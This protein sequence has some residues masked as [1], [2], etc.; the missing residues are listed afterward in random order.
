GGDPYR[1]AGPSFF[2]GES[3]LF[4]SLNRGKESL[5]LNLKSGEGRRIFLEKLVP[6]FDA[7]IENFSPGT[8]DSL[9]LGYE[10]CKEA[11]PNI[12]YSS[13]S[14][15]GE[16]G[17]SREKKGFDLIL[18]SV[19]GIMDLTGEKD[20]GPV[21]VGI[22]ITDFAAGFV[23][24][25]GILSACYERGNSQGKA[26][27]LDT[28]LYESSISL[29]SI[30]ACDYFASGEV[31]HRMGSASPTFAP[32]QAF[33]C[34]D[35]FITIAGAGSE[36]MWQRFARTIGMPHLTSDTRFRMNSDRVKNQEVLT[37][38]INKKLQE[39]DAK[40]WL[41]IFDSEGVP[42]GAVNTLADVLSDEQTAAL[43]LVSAVPVHN[44]DPQNKFRSIRLPLNINGKPVVSQNSP[45]LLGEHTDLVLNEVGLQSDDLQ[46]LRATKVIL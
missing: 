13:I 2:Q 18:Q 30:L 35:S 7:V 16:Q 1:K 5:A 43:K 27:E 22:P 26:T 42:C 46:T 21:K 23:S 45:P 19:T 32:Y 44:S 38:L 4:L 37:E 12:I 36:E 31:P 14:G 39:K 25:I 20:S 28:S 17:P 33:R 40:E 10:K 9:G 29:L 11:N 8:M 24:A 15:F 3:T 34:R 6:T 41:E